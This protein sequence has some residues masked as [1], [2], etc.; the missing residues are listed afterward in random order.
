MNATERKSK[1]QK[2]KRREQEFS[3]IN[4]FEVVGYLIEGRKEW[5]V[6]CI[7]IYICL[8]ILDLFT[9]LFPVMLEG[10]KNCNKKQ[11]RV[12]SFSSVGFLFR[13]VDDRSIKN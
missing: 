13:I 12:V 6:I 7:Y 1:K 11:R 8:S 9:T 2:K 5:K 4:K 3:C 10:I